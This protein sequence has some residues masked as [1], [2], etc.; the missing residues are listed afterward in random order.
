ML[1]YVIRHGDPDYSTDSLT[2][3]GREQA[4]K[5]AH[6]LLRAHIDEVFCS[7]KGRA[8]ETAEAFTRLTGL[9]KTIVEWAREFP[10]H[11]DA[12]KYGGPTVSKIPPVLF[13][14]EYD[15]LDYDHGMD[16]PAFG[17]TRF[18]E[19]FEIMRQGAFDFLKDHGYEYDEEK[20]YFNILNPNEKRVALFCHGNMGRALT[21][22]LLHL[23]IQTVFGGF[24]L[25]H[26]A[27]TVFWFE[28]REEGITVPKCLTLGDVTHLTT[29]EHGAPYYDKVEF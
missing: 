28:N 11:I 4:E 3:L 22:Y 25:A 1:L 16:Y 12:E 29:E 6:R 27:I 26:T 21:S 19:R 7:P 5:C 18:R 14:G 24:G 15:K 10:G 8:I 9:D 20:G 17:E 13:R 2:A 23:P